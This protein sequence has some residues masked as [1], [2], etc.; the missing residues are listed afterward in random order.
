MGPLTA[1]AAFGLLTMCAYGG[2][3]EVIRGWRLTESERDNYQR[4]KV[5]RGWGL[6][7]CNYNSQLFYKSEGNARISQE[8]MWSLPA[9][10]WAHVIPTGCVD[11]MKAHVISTRCVM[12]AHVIPTRCVMRAHAIPTCCVMRAHVIPTCCVMRNTWSSSEDAWPISDSGYSVCMCECECV[13][14]CV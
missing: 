11:V 3:S 4:V 2:I 10:S 1:A 8:L 9:V 12:R 5:I 13:C 6:S 7:S 14:L